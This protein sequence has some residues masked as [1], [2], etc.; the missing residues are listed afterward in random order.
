MN[1]FQKRSRKVREGKRQV[2]PRNPLRNL[3][4]LANFA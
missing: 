1:N 2:S 3:A 4:H